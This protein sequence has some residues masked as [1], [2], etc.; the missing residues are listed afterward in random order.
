MS[1]CRACGRDVEWVETNLGRKMPLDPDPDR[2]G[3]VVKLGTTN[4]QGAPIVRV[5]RKDDPRVPGRMYRSHF[6]T[7]P[8][9][10]QFRR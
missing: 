9:A 4:A 2:D 1:A 10:D 3:N 8:K 5:L 7:C 6:Q